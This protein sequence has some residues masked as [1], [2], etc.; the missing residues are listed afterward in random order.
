[1]WVG[2]VAQ[3]DSGDM[4][5]LADADAASVGRQLAFFCVCVRVRVR[6]RARAKAR[7]RACELLR[8]CVR[9]LG[10]AC[11]RAVGVC[12]RAGAGVRACA[13]KHVCARTGRVCART[14]R[15]CAR[16]LDTGPA[17]SS[18]PSVHHV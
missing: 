14:G 12:V 17:R 10:G 8:A 15:V 1:M 11:V 9:D 6:V 5:W 3:A 18:R 16:G 4:A 7:I 2:G 13:C